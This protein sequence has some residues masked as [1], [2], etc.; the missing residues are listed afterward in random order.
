MIIS[1]N[2]PLEHGL[3]IN[4]TNIKD[5]DTKN[6]INFMSFNKSII[7]NMS[8]ILLSDGKKF[9]T[10]LERLKLAFNYLDEEYLKNK[11]ESFNNQYDLAFDS[12]LLNEINREKKDEKQTKSLDLQIIEKKCKY[13]DLIKSCLR[14]KKAIK[15]TRNN[16]MIDNSS[17]SYSEESSEK[18]EN[19]CDIDISN[20]NLTSDSKIIKNNVNEN[21]VNN[22]EVSSNQNQNQAN[23]SLDSN[24]SNLIINSSK[25]DLIIDDNIKE[26]NIHEDSNIEIENENINQQNIQ[27]IQNIQ[28]KSTSN[29]DISFDERL[30]IKTNLNSCSNTDNRIRENNKKQIFGKE[31]YQAINLSKCIKRKLV[32]ND[33]V[34][35]K[36]D[37][38]VNNFSNKKNNDLDLLVKDKREIQ[39]ILNDENAFISYIQKLS[40][41]IHV[42]KSNP[43]GLK[44]FLKS[45]LSVIISS[46]FSI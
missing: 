7:K 22:I 10:D 16:I 34:Y 25:S 26:N 13:T 37:I 33:R 1:E 39:R 24:S 20:N 23:N 27:N 42:L 11:L 3:N 17:K 29:D 36:D 45:N 46:K 2:K 12:I 40:E 6:S 9:Q 15:S 8:N 41:T 38:N 5:T 32:N 14:K 30:E 19:E 31:V 35:D 44:Q 4:L 43:N 18:F 28:N 21:P